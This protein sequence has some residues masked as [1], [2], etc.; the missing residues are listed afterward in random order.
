MF[1]QIGQKSVRKATV[2]YPVV[3]LV[4]AE[5]IYHQAMRMKKKFN[6][7]YMVLTASL[8]THAAL[9]FLGFFLLE[10]FHSF[11]FYAFKPTLEILLQFQQSF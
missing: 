8:V 6:C 3:G 11:L 10:T 4:R 5:W 9:I 2:E 7:E 1:L